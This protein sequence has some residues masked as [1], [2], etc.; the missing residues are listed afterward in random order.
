MVEIG[1]LYG[2]PLLD[3]LPI[4]G[5]MSQQMASADDLLKV[6]RVSERTVAAYEVLTEKYRQECNK[7]E[8]CKNLIRQVIGGHWTITMLQEA[9]NEI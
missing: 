1:P 5:G 9:I 3:T 2:V 6:R 8:E 4:G 7:V